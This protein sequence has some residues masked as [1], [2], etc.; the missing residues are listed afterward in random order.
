MKL[1][2]EGCECEDCVEKWR[3]GE[4]E[5]WSEDSVLKKKGVNVKSTQWRLLKAKTQKDMYH[6]DACTEPVSF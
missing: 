6:V 5:R 2:Q 3:G 1:T 4:V